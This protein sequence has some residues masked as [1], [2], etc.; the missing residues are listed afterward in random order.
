MAAAGSSD[1]D[2]LA[3]TAPG[4]FGVT[5]KPKKKSGGKWDGRVSSLSIEQ[6]RDMKWG[7][8]AGFRS[9]LKNAPRY[10]MRPYLAKPTRSNSD[11][12]LDTN[13]YK[14]F[15]AAH[16]VAP[17]FSMGQ[18]SSLGGGPDHTP[19]PQYNIPGCME[20]NGHPTIHK[21]TGSKF[22]TEVPQVLD[23]E[24]PAP[25]QY[26][27]SDFTKLGR[28]KRSPVYTCQGREAWND[29]AKDGVGPAPGEYNYEKTTRTGKITPFKWN[30]QGKTE[31][32]EKPRGERRY[33][34]PGP[35][36]YPTPAYGSRNEF[37]SQEKPAQWKFT[38]D[39]RGL[40]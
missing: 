40:L 27:V 5:R 1:A 33:A 34:R 3:A 13:V 37:C 29:A 14:A 17:S 21:H 39:V 9:A 26:N 18:S 28:Y 15:D 20:P 35:G 30:M 12:M 38:Q 32:L 11:G 10:T 19:G 25:G 36:Q 4:G 22:G 24:A 8:D 7:L 23:E 31:P 2:A 16:A 6:Y